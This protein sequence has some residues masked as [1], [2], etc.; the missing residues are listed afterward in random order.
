MSYPWIKDSQYG[1]TPLETGYL[2]VTSPKG[3]Y[4]NS[5]T[6]GTNSNAIL[7]T[8]YIT[9][10]STP[11]T[12][13]YYADKV[14]YLNSSNNAVTTYQTSNGNT[15]SNIYTDNEDIYITSQIN[16]GSFTA[17]A[18]A[19]RINLYANNGLWLNGLQITPGGGGGAVNSVSAGSQG[20]NVNPTTGNVVVDLSLTAGTGISVANTGYGT[21][22]ID[23]TG[24]AG[25]QGPQGDTGPAGGY[26][27]KVQLLQNISAGG[28][29]NNGA[30]VPGWTTF[31]TSQGGL[32]TFYLTFSAQSSNPGQLC[33]FDLFANGLGNILVGKI[34]YY[35]NQNANAGIDH[36]TIP[37]VFSDISL[38]AGN[39]YFELYIPGGAQVNS[40]DFAN[41]LI[42]EVIGANSIG[43]TGP[44]G[45]QG[46][47]GRTG[48]TGAQ[49]RTGAQGATGAQGFQGSTGAQGFQGATGA[50]GA[51]GFQ[52]ATGAQ[53]RTGAQGA[54]GAVG[55]LIGAPTITTLTA[56]TTGQTLQ[57]NLGSLSQGTGVM[58]L[59]GGITSTTS[60]TA[61]N[62]TFGI[63]YGSYTLILPFSTVSPTQTVTINAVNTTNYRCNFTTIT[64]SLTNTGVTKYIVLGVAYD[65]AAAIYYISGS[66]FG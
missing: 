24:V 31:Y 36:F 32:L 34:S 54:T 53:G 27:N 13:Y 43:V 64:C 6:S 62:F 9:G 29:Y 55:I 39:Y 58:T 61:Y 12:A 38:P 28:T 66:V 16:N 33:E 30:I 42:E 4:L 20:I 48:A 37:C 26:I 63:Q 19:G 25:P 59:V 51:T 21:W 1:T 18:G 41:M 14:R 22:Q 35:F 10:G 7:M 52:G 57:V 56:S 46:A 11:S 2:E 23:N 15:Q 40:D 50:Q 49:G 5:T 45:A 17:P 60:V 8:G 44:Q 3:L 65:S 47:Q